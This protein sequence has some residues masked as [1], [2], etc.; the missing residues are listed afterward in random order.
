MALAKLSPL[1]SELTATQES[2]N[3][4]FGRNELWDA[5]ATLALAD[6]APSVD[7]IESEDEVTIKAELPGVEAKDIA[8]TVDNNVLTIKGERHFEKDVKKENYHRM[9][10]AYGKLCPSFW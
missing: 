10:H 7:I 2:L 5:E 3:R 8:V 4:L 9:E 6:W 1:I